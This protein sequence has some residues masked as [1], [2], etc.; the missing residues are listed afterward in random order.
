MKIESIDREMAQFRDVQIEKDLLAAVQIEP[1]TIQN[2]FIRLPGDFAYWGERYRLA[3]ISR[4]E[5]KL[6]FQSESSRLQRVHR[7]R[8]LSN[9]KATESM[10]EG[11]LHEDPDYHDLYRALSLADIEME[12]MAHNVKAVTIKKDALVSLGSLIRQE[13]ENDPI[14]KSRVMDRR[15]AEN[16]LF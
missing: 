1:L 7:E 2:E 13:L 12:A 9:G 16:P 6:K 15:A 5:I 3:R 8:L 14:V 10:V 4:D 11:A